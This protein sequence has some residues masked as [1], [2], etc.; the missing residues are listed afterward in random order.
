MR[1]QALAR[2]ELGGDL[3]R[4]LERG[5]FT[6]HYQ[7]MVAMSTGR[8]IGFEAFVY[9]EHPERGLLAP[10]AFVPLAEEMGLIVPLGRWVLGESCRQFRRW[11]DR[12]GDASPLLMSVNVSARQFQHPDLASEVATA[13]G[14]AGVAPE[15]LQLE[16]TE[17]AVMADEAAVL[18]A[19]ERL[20]GQRVRLTIDDFGTG[21]ASLTYLRRLPVDGL[22]IDRSFVAGLTRGGEDAAIV[23]AVV[24]LGRALGLEVTAEGVETAEQAA[25]LRAIGCDRAQGYLFGRPQP[26]E[27]IESLLGTM[28]AAS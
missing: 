12:W 7:P 17:S 25:A 11:Q 1:E 24:R 4:A 26:G 18:V 13:L 21:Y 8:T 9:W 28:A 22:K 20:R 15:R 3:R 16:L 2:L 10:G 5:E 14:A 19:L 6:L 23:E 27:V